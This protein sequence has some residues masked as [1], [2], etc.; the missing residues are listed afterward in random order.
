MKKFVRIA[1]LVLVVLMSLSVFA[2]CKGNG[3]KDN[4]SQS[5]VTDA[6]FSTADVQFAAAEGGNV[7]RIIRQEGAEKIMLSAASAISKSIKAIVGKSPKNTDDTTAAD[8]NIPEIL[9]GETNRE[10]TKAAKNYLIEQAGRIGDYIIATINNKIVVYGMTDEATAEAAA[11]FVDNFVK[12]EGVKGGIKYLFVKEGNFIEGS[13]NGNTKLCRYTVVRPHFNCAYLTQIEI[14]RLIATVEEKSGYRINR[15]DDF[16][17]KENETEKIQTPVAE[18]E[19]IVGNSMRDGVKSITVED[20]YEIRIEGKKVYL[21]GGSPY[22]T[23]MAVTKFTDMLIG[24]NKVALTDANTATLSWK[25]TEAAFSNETYYKPTW[26]DEFNGTEVDTTKWT[27]DYENVTGYGRMAADGKLCKRNRLDPP[28][29]GVKDGVLYMTAEQ[30][31]EAYYGGMFYTNGTMRYTY[32]LLEVSNIH[33]KG[34]GFWVAT[35]T[36]SDKGPNNLA[37]V[38]VDV[39][40]CYGAGTWV[41][42]NTFSWPTSYGKSLGYKTLHVNNRFYSQDGR[43]LW[44]DFHTFGYEWDEATIRFTADGVVYAE[45][46]MQTDPRDIDAFCMPQLIRISLSTASSEHGLPTQDPEEWAN[47][48]S[49]IVDYCYVYQ[50]EG[51]LLFINPDPTLNRA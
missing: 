30:D 29:S 20:E 50:K 16:D 17:V 22:A 19:I 4:S 32:G 12:A 8:A 11:Y 47:T 21:N 38:E 10:E 13:I 45:Q 43:G 3:D 25:A 24:N 37:S 44:M 6:N 31:D 2:A 46:D 48:A 5:G 1:C 36:M 51:Q 23:A 41:Y 18:Y 34:N 39:D 7:Y 27:I 33:P 49:Y 35:W 14:D 42:G 26:Y 15:A 40:E 9:L 28:N